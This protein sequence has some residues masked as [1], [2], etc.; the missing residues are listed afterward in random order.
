MLIIIPPCIRM[1]GEIPLIS[2]D[3]INISLNS[4]LKFHISQ[5]IPIFSCLHV[6][7]QDSPYESAGLWSGFARLSGPESLLFRHPHRIGGAMADLLSQI[8]IC[9]Y[10]K[11]PAGAGMYKYIYIYIYIYMYIWVNY[12]ELTASSLDIIVIYVYANM[13]GIY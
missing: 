11:D 5:H 13:T 2:P 8:S 4:I 6:I 3:V 9:P 7:R 10:P 12:N 1:A